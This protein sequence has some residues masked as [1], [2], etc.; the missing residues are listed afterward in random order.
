MK[1]SL[2]DPFG[3]IASQRPPLDKSALL[4]QYIVEEKNIK[5]NILCSN[6]RRKQEKHND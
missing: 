5:H 1:L 2:Q 3:G 6:Y 4:W